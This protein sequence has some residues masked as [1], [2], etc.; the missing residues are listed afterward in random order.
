MMFLG[1]HYSAVTLAGWG[2]INRMVAPGM[3]LSEAQHIA[4][5]L[6]QNAPLSIQTI[7]HMVNVGMDLSLPD[8][9]QLER[10]Q[11]TAL[12]ATDDVREGIQAFVERRKPQ[13]KGK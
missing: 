9:R 8:A 11:A 2:L 3:A 5:R 4:R 10:E 6:A 12:F 13:F 7:K 1:D